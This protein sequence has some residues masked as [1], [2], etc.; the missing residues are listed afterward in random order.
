M[1]G[2]FYHL[3][4]LRP[5][6]DAGNYFN[7]TSKGMAKNVYKS[8]DELLPSYIGQLNGLYGYSTGQPTEQAH[9]V[10]SP[11][12]TSNLDVV[13]INDFHCSHGNSTRHSR[14]RRRSRLRLS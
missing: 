13:I 8:V 1:S 9:A 3:M 10:L 11:G 12:G 2:L 7:G 6:E 4:S 5:T 14:A